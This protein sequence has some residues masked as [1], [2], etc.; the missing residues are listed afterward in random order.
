MSR[1]DPSPN[2]SGDTTRTHRTDSLIASIALDCVLASADYGDTEGTRA[3]IRLFDRVAG[4]RR[5]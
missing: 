3:S 1:H 2:K 5:A 4:G